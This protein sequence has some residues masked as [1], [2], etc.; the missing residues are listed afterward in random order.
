MFKRKSSYWIIPAALV[1]AAGI[2]YIPAVNSR[3]S[4]R[5]DD[6]YTR[7]AY[8]LNPPEEAVFQPGQQVDVT[9]IYL[10]TRAQYMLTLTPKPT[11]THRIGPTP[12]PTITPTPLPATVNIPGVKYVDQHGRWNYCG[13]A[14]LTMALNFWGWKGN[15]D[16]VA[17][18]VK[19]GSSDL[20]KDFIE[21]GL[22]DKNVM[23]YEMIDFVN[24]QT[25]YRALW[26]YG[27]NMELIKALLANGFP[28]VI[29]KGYLARD[30]TGKVSWMGHYEFATGYDD[31]KGT[32]LV[33]DAYEFGPNYQMAYN[34]IEEGWR[35]FNYLFFIVYPPERETQLFDLLG[36]WS[37]SKWATQHA[38][39]EAENNIQNQNGVELYFAWFNKGTNHMALQQYVDAAAAYDYAFNLYAQLDCKTIKCP[40]RMMWYQTGPYFA[41][42]YTGRY[43]D[44]I[45][46]A[47]TTLN[48]TIAKPT[49]EE[50][51]YWRG[52]AYA[53][54]GNTQAAIADFRAALDVHV[55][56]LPALQALQDLGVQ[57]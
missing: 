42:F 22:P 57:P 37:E 17:R 52:R 47:D 23:P 15:R 5:L 44:V 20:S 48:E 56:W 35:A 49:L 13:P 11:A 34:E 45:Q 46:L 41:Y 50:S 27:G 39:E 54:T 29:E 9:A 18:V 4:W 31:A 25:E 53:M 1:L 36:P 12:R 3:L 33:Q 7:V 43:Q 51:L 19:P 32:L 10:T 8:F 40:F 28:V 24:E 55:D 6:L 21:R 38:L 16:D 2:Y 14:N 30:T 26:R